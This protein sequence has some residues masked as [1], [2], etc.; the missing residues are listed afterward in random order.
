MDRGSVLKRMA[1]RLLPFF[2]RTL[3]HTHNALTFALADVVSHS[4]WFE[5]TDD[6]RLNMHMRLPRKAA[7]C[8]LYYTSGFDEGTIVTDFGTS[9]LTAAARLGLVLIVAVPVG[10]C[11]LFCVYW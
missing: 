6:T 9:T 7:D 8:T 3:T 1:K 10:V 2:L 5:D 4:V 11:V